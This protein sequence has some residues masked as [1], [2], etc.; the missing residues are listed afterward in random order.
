MQSPERRLS[1]EQDAV[2]KNSQPTQIISNQ[3]SPD[4]LLSSTD[5]C[6]LQSISSDRG[7]AHLDGSISLTIES[8]HLL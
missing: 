5:N 7:Q 1:S 3:H 4:R 6:I 2:F 8:E